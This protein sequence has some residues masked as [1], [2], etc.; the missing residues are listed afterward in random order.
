MIMLNNTSEIIVYIQELPISILLIIEFK[1]KNH[2]E[3]TSTQKYVYAHAK[4]QFVFFKMPQYNYVSFFF[5][6]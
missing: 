1:I 4:K 5:F 2:K 6:L 3:P